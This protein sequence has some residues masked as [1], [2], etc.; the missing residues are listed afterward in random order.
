MGAQRKT[1]CVDFDGV[2]NSYISGWK[3]VEQVTDPPVRGAIEW[4]LAMLGEGFD[5][6]IYSS[7]SKE[8]AGVQAMRDALKRWGMHQDDI[9]R[10]DFPTQKPAAWLTIDDRCVR[11]DGN[12]EALTADAINNFKPWNKP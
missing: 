3:G 9:D 11:F 1:L 6:C 5:V 7:R 12:F 8:A 2:I 10:I 4:L